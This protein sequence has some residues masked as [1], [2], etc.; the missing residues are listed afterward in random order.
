MSAIIPYTYGNFPVY[1]FYIA[2][3]PYS[4]AQ[5][6]FPLNFLETSLVD[7]PEGEEVF[8]R[9]KFNGT[10]LFGTNSL[11]TDVFGAT[12]NRRD[13]WLHFW[14]AEQ[15]NPCD[16][17]Y[18]V[19]TKTVGGVATTY[20]DGYFST[21]D[22]KFDIDNCT[23]EVT[24][25]L[26][27]DY[28]DILEAANIQY[29]ILEVTPT[30]S[31]IALQGL[32]GIT[33]DRNRWLAKSAAIDNP[34]LD[35]ENVIHFLADKVKSGVVVSSDFFTHATNP[36]TLNAN[37]L[38]Y[39]TIAQKS[40]IRRP[41]SSD[42]ATS[43]LMSWNELTAILWA[44]FQVKWNYVPG[45]NTI[46]V[47]HV[48]WSGFAPAP[49]LDLRLQPA[50]VATNKYTYLK[51]KMPKY[52]KFAFMESY[53]RNF[54]GSPIY[55]NSQCVDQDPETNIKETAIKVTTDLEYI[56]DNPD[57]ISDEGFVIL[58]NYLNGDYYVELQPGAFSTEV[59]L[60]MHLSWANLHHYY[61]R[62]N[63]VLIRGF[64]N[65]T[66]IDFWSAQKTKL[67]ECSAIVCDDF[68]PSEKITTELG[69]T[70]FLGAKAVVQRSE[71][72][73]SGEVKLNL[74]YGP[75]DNVNTGVPDTLK[76]LRIEQAEILHDD[77]TNTMYAFLTQAADM[78]IVIKIRATQY[79]SAGVWICGPDAWDT[80]TIATG[81]FTDSHVFTFCG[82]LPVDG[83]VVYEFDTSGAGT[84]SVNFIQEITHICP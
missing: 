48:S 67:Q 4:N 64:L 50:C 42:M 18:F 59:R 24:P 29:N 36:A 74:L 11:T 1:R 78:D 3:V 32:T 54:F 12:V 52:E 62:H 15:N 71:I 35:A 10:L 77:I 6:V 44:M 9:R 25:L 8:Y 19:I 13:D 30:V 83:C 28:T 41:T 84:W 22:G 14:D 81:S 61:Y 40:D 7:E 21:T 39:L 53:G 45:T 17:I 27:D 16:K 20:W 49:G 47:E 60:N 26:N 63:R 58:C 51:D 80:W 38:L 75:A 79:D 33:Y 82:I 73:P 37:H 57:V 43:A 55:Y 72:R 66:E 5:E 69:E 2:T 65:G 34:V 23:F 46:N 56:I 76:Y 31:T 68:D 70:Y